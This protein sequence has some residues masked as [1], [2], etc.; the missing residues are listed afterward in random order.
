MT[1]KAEFAKRID[2]FFTMYGYKVNS[3]KVPE[4]KSRTNWNYV[5]TIDVNIDGAIPAEDM[6]QLKAIYDEGV[7]LW[8]TTDNFLDYSKSNPIR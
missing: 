1:I 5:Q 3:L 7:T 2:S 6:R 4:L 8:H